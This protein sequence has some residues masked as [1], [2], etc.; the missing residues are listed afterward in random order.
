[1]SSLLYVDRALGAV[2]RR[3]AGLLLLARRDGAV[4]EH[5][6]VALVVVSEQGR[7]EVVTAAVP[8]A[9]ARDDRDLH[10]VP[11]AGAVAASA[12]GDGAVGDGG[13]GGAS[14]AA[15]RV[16]SAAQSRSPRS[17]L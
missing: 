3:Q 6:P 12:V 8:L 14:A 5:R 10:G 9:A 13:P 17:R 7:R 4:A 16:S 11:P 2:G 15:I 1:M